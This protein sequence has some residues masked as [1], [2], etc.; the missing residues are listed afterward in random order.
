MV[1]RILIHKSL[2]I[3]VTTAEEEYRLQTNIGSHGIRDFGHELQYWVNYFIR[4]VGTQF[5]KIEKLYLDKS[6]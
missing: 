1:V 3:A 5:I 4:Y 6:N 2:K